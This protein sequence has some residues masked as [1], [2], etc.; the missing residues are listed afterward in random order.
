M[1]YASKAVDTAWLIINA[2]PRAVYLAFLFDALGK[3]GRNAFGDN[4]GGDLADSEIFDLKMKL[5]AS[6]CA[7][8]QLYAELNAEKRR[9]KSLML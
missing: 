4:N 3:N 7:N 6:E 1:E 9:A 8:A 2:A 5:F